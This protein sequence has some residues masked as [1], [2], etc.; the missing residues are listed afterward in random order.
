MKRALWKSWHRHLNIG[1][2]I[3]ASIA[4]FYFCL[5][6]TF[7]SITPQYSSVCLVISFLPS[8]GVHS[9]YRKILFEFLEESINLPKKSYPENFERVLIKTLFVESFLTH[10]KVSLRILQK[11]IQNR[12]SVEDLLAFASVKG[13]YTRNFLDF[14]KTEGRRLYFVLCKFAN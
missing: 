9:C 8:R 5:N 3:R 7:M 4:K 2:N 10:L 13:N 11:T 12:F 6:R 1:T 14:R